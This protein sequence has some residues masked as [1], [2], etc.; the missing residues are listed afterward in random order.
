LWFN[1]TVQQ[2]Q[3]ISIPF[4]SVWTGEETL[5]DHMAFTLNDNDITGVSETF[6]DLPAMVDDLW[7]KKK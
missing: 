2:Y 7:K 3:N 1:I 4:D 6:R 5:N